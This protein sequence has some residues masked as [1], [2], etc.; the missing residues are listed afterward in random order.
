VVNQLHA[1]ERSISVFDGNH[2]HVIEIDP[3]HIE[4]ARQ[5]PAIEHIKR[6]K[7]KENVC[8]TP[9]SPTFAEWLQWTRQMRIVL[10]TSRLSL[11]PF[12]PTATRS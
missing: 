1:R 5:K 7:E 3:T 12:L 4:I 6:E 10:G 2:V 11:S 8:W 9:T